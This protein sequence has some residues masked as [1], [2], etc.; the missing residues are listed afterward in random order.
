MKLFSHEV[1]QKQWASV[2]YRKNMSMIGLIQKGGHQEI[3]AIASYADEGN[4]KAEIAFVVREDFQGLGVATH[5]LEVLEKIAKENNFIGFSATVL[6][7]NTGMLR[8]FKKRYPSTKSSRAAGNEIAL[9]MLFSDAV[10]QSDSPGK[11][12]D[13]CTID[14]AN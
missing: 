13:G 6:S 1:V 14:A 8:V 12:D 11:P 7:E 5:L 4:G 2:D 9:E 10:N 3:M